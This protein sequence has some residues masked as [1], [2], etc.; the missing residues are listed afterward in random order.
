[1]VYPGLQAFLEDKTAAAPGRQAAQMRLLP[2][3]VYQFP[4]QEA[5]CAHFRRA[6]G[7]FVGMNQGKKNGSK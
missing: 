6:A 2:V 4:A 7:L 1:L 5:A 3:P